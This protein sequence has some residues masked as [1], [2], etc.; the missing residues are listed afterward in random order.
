MRGHPRTGRRAGCGHKVRCSCGPTGSCRRSSR[1]WPPKSSW[2]WRT[3]GN[4]DRC[5]ASVGTVDRVDPRDRCQVAATPTRLTIACPSTSR[6]RP[7]RPRSSGRSTY[8]PAPDQ[9]SPAPGDARSCAAPQPPARSVDIPCWAESPREGH[10][11]HGVRDE[12]DRRRQVGRW[13]CACRPLPERC[14]D[15][16]RRIRI[17]VRCVS[18]LSCDGLERDLVAEGPGTSSAGSRHDSHPS[19]RREAVG[20]SGVGVG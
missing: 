13:R 16:M 17:N 3:A 20:I 18:T 4:G 12:P 10:R 19:W 15:A 6:A 7:S 8:G 2:T 1:C 11:S 5:G 9:S 14:E